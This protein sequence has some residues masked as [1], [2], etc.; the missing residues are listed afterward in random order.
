MAECSLNYITK[1][2]EILNQVCGVIDLDGYLI[3]KTFTVREMGWC[4]YKCTETYSYHYF[5][6]NPFP[7][8]DVKACQ[9]ITYVY[10]RVHGLAYYPKYRCRSPKRWENDF[11]NIYEKQPKDRPFVAYKGGHLEKDFLK[12]LGI[13]S[14]NLELFGCP[15]FDDMTR[16]QTITS[17][18]HHLHPSR[19]HCPKVECFHFIKWM[20]N[21]LIK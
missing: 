12:R 9:T 14:I 15:K 2:E 5:P 16:L 8:D 4:N 1:E 20:L 18:G 13:P 7:K 3:K 17:C 11:L 21:N 6:A 19:H 10:N